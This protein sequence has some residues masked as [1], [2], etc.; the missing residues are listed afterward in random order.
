M[1][2]LWQ[3][4]HDVVVVT[5]VRHVNVN[6]QPGIRGWIERAH[7]DPNPLF[8]DRVPEQGRAARGAKPSPHLLGGAEPTDGWSAKQVARTSE[9]DTESG[10]GLQ[11]EFTVT[12]A[13]SGE[14]ESASERPRK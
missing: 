2:V 4:V 1:L 8:L 3:T 7:S 14:G 10:G 12:I 11:M 5:F 9:L 13:A 6:F